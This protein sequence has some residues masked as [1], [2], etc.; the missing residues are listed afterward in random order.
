MKNLPLPNYAFP[1]RHPSAEPGD[2]GADFRGDDGGSICVY[3]EK[4]EGG[5]IGIC[6]DRSG[7]S[8][9]LFTPGEM[10]KIC[11]LLPILAKGVGVPVKSPVNPSL[12]EA[13]NSGNGTYK[14]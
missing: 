1:Y 7:L 8:E 9:S 10:A 4:R 2:F 12:D 11:E 14:P 5:M 6:L 13:L 3:L